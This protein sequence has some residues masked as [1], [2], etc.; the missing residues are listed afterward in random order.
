MIELGK[1]QELTVIKRVEFGVYLGEQEGAEERVLLPDKQVP[2]GTEV[3]S[4]LTAFVYKDSRGPADC[5]H[6]MNRRWTLGGLA[7]LTVARGRED[8]RFPGLGPGEGSVPALPGADAA[9][10]RGRGGAWWRSTSTRVSRL[11]A[12]MNVYAYLRTAFALQEGRSCKRHY[13]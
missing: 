6:Q 8:R 7:V 9:G 13:L 1:K 2:E 4:K 3:G 5:H 12:T 11:C 10:A